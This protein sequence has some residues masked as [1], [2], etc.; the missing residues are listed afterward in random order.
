M[1]AHADAASVEFVDSAN[2]GTAFEISRLSLL[3]L[4][5]QQLMA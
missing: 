5:I 4:E 1:S 2:I 3:E